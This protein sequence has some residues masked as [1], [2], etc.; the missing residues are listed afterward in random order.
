MS[1]KIKSDYVKNVLNIKSETA[2][3]LADFTEAQK[4][5]SNNITTDD[6]YVQF[7]LSGYLTAMEDGA[8][9]AGADLDLTYETAANIRSAL[10]ALTTLQA[11]SDYDPNRNATVTMKTLAAYLTLLAV[12]NHDLKI[13]VERMVSNANAPRP[14]LWSDMYTIKFNLKKK[15]DLLPAAIKGLNTP[16][17][18]SDGFMLD[19]DQLIAT[20]KKVTGVDLSEYGLSQI[21][22]NLA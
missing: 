6:L 9:A 11:K 8:E 18:I 16:I 13:S 19:F 3:V 22:V 10:I 1:Y 12:N 14:E 4:Y 17:I 21:V 7:V 15:S 5:I 2:D 20:Y